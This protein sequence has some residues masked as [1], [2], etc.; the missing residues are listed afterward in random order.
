[1]KLLKVS[2]IVVAAGSGRRFGY[3]RNKL[4]YSLCGK[5]VLT[6]TL[7][8]VFAAKRVQEVVI[9]NS[10]QDHEE[11]ASI[12]E[13]LHPRMTV[14]YAV[15]GAEREDSVYNGLLATSPDMDIV[16]VHD[17]A[18]PLAGPEWYDN[19]VP[20]MEHAAAAIYAIP[21]KDTVKLRETVDNTGRAESVRTL[22]RS[23]LI[24]AQTPQIFHRDV[25]LRAHEYAQAHNLMGT[26]DAS[27]VEAIGEKIVVLQG[28]QRN[29]KVT[30]MDDV[31]VL[32]FY[33]NGPTEHRVGS[34]YDVHPLAAGR[35]LILGGVEIPFERG[36]DGHSDADVLAHAIMDALLGAA[37]LKDIGTYFPDTDKAFKNIS[38][39]VLLE[40]VRQ[41]LI[42]NSCRIINVDATLMAQRPKIKPYVSKMIANIAH[43]LQIDKLSVSVKA[44]TTEHLGFVGQEEG[45]A[46]QAAAMVLKYRNR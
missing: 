13:S 17:G 16:M 10:E 6:H 36:L 28:D 22:D 2:V 19:A 27:L 14:R 33:L 42:E 18:R 8:R 29:H 35:K 26:D 7:E 39:L 12:V 37:G 43:A 20:V 34:G 9:V 3:E 40:K 45:M 32:E 5:P 1:M 46:A 30:T 25:L 23:R 24:A 11:I 31:P 15:G 21:L 41:I 4:F 44:T 38:S